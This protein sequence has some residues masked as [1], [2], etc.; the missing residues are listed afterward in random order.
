M[1][2]IGVFDI[3]LLLNLCSKNYIYEDNFYITSLHSSLAWIYCV[4]T[5]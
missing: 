5:V 3:G 2:L 4:I 1:I